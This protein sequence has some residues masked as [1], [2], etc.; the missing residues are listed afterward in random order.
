[1]KE[2]KVMKNL[3]LAAL[4]LL[5]FA[6]PSFAQTATPITMSGEETSTM[7]AGKVPEGAM[8]VFTYQ[9]GG[10]QPFGVYTMSSNKNAAFEI[11]GPDGGVMATSTKDEFGAHTW[12]GVLESPGM[13]TIVVYSTGDGLA[14]FQM[15][16]TAP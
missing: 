13:Y 4:I 8:Q 3:I 14:D 15:T 10:N 6:V 7:L 12:K 11:T 5:C 2:L 1:M 16:V 9:T